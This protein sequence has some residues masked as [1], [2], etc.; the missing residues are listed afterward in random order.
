MIR[1]FLISFVMGLMMISIAHNTYQT[2]QSV[3]RC[4]QIIAEIHQHAI[5]L[6]EQNYD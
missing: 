4:E 6:Q 1:A 3:A 5:N 2:K